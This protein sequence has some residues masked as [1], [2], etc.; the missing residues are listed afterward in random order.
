MFSN[1]GSATVESLCEMDTTATWQSKMVGIL[2]GDH[3][4]ERK[5]SVTLQIKVIYVNFHQVF[6]L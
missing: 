6:S 3:Q 1:D 2:L 5:M 4:S